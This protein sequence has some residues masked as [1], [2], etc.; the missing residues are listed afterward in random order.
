M[1]FLPAL[2]VFLLLF[3]CADSDSPSELPADAHSV[4]RALEAGHNN[5]LAD[6]LNLIIVGKGYQNMDEFL[7]TVH[8]DLAFDGVEQPNPES[9]DK[10]HFGL[11]A[12]EPFKSQRSKFNL[13][14]YPEQL[15]TISP[16]DFI[17]QKRDDLTGSARDFGLP[18][19]TYLFFLNPTG[20]PQSFAYP[21]NVPPGV[22]PDKKT[23]LFGSATVARYPTIGDGMAV[24]AHELG[25]SIFNLRDEYVRTS[26][27]FIDRYGHNIA[28]T[29]AEARQLWGS[30]EGQVDP[31]YYT[32]KEKMMANGFWIDRSTPLFM[33]HDAKRGIDIYTWH[34]HEEEIR[35]G[36]VQGGGITTT[37]ISWR[38]TKT[39]LMNNEDIWDKSW[40]RFPPVFGAANRR[41]MHTVLDLF[42][43]N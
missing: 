14:Y 6:R 33:Q 30:V 18:F 9:I 10:V 40:P 34:P 15:N 37:G 36:Y 3:S 23:L 13:W 31:F 26:P 1:K 20:D 8:R 11:F 43:G 24:V 2:L 4:L 25:H 32:W 28:R 39:S 7:A 27:D 21:S 41:V 17:S 5:R 16:A 38:P 12:I 22:A 29:T 42:S 35:A 19:A